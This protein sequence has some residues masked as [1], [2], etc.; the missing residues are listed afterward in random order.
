MSGTCLERSAAPDGTVAEVCYLWVAFF[1]LRNALKK[2]K[3]FLAMWPKRTLRLFVSAIR[4]NGIDDVNEKHLKY[5]Q[6]VTTKYS[7]VF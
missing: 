4:L 2:E 6:A 1:V 3:K 5:S 7:F